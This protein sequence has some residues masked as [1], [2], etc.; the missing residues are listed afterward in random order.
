MTF[1][2]IYGFFLLSRFHTTR[3]SIRHDKNA[4]SNF[5]LPTSFSTVLLLTDIPT[6]DY[7]CNLKTVILSHLWP[8]KYRLATRG[9]KLWL[10]LNFIVS[11]LVASYGIPSYRT[12]CESVKVIS[13]FSTF[14]RIA[15]RGVGPSVKGPL[16]WKIFKPTTKSIP[17]SYLEILC[18]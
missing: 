4:V 14:Y 3:D 18:L 5:T 10:Q 8:H 6:T 2:K 1:P 15:S 17:H 13:L 9:W 12:L 7:S 11:F 16:K